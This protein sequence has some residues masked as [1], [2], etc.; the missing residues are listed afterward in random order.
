MSVLFEHKTLIP[1]GSHPMLWSTLWNHIA[2][3][4][5]ANHWV[6]WNMGYVRVRAMGEQEPHRG[7]GWPWRDPTF[8]ITGNGDRF[9]CI[10]WSIRTNHSQKKCIHCFTDSFFFWISWSL[11]FGPIN[12]K[13]RTVQ[14]CKHRRSVNHTC[15]PGVFPEQ[16]GWK[17]TIKPN[18]ETKK[19]KA[20]CADTQLT[21]LC[22][23]PF[24]NFCCILRLQPFSRSLG[25]RSN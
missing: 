25:T 14:I 16:L 12:Y 8:F 10:D 7:W 20:G 19:Q 15:I 24:W 13:T 21:P 22:I 11:A 5:G 2:Y 3:K 1:C 4:E 23:F 9:Y 18:E 6:A 17:A